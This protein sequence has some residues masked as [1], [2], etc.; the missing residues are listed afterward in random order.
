MTS[1]YQNTLSVEH[2]KEV[3][4]RPSSTLRLVDPQAIPTT[5]QTYNNNNNPIHFGTYQDCGTN[6][7]EGASAGGV[8]V[9][10]EAMISQM[11]D[12]EGSRPSERTSREDALGAEPSSNKEDHFHSSPISSTSPGYLNAS[13][14][15][16]QITSTQPH[17]VTDDV[18]GS[19]G[20]GPEYFGQ[21]NGGNEPVSGSYRYQR[22]SSSSSSPATNSLKERKRVM[23]ASSIN[24][25]FEELRLHVPTFPYEKR[26]SKIDTLRLAIAYIALLREILDHSDIMEPLVY[27]ERC[28][29][30]EIRNEGTVG[31]NTSDLTAR[32]AWINWDNLGVGPSR[33]GILSNLQLSSSSDSLMMG[34]S[35][36]VHLPPAH[37][38]DLHDPNGVGHVY[39]SHNPSAILHAPHSHHHH[40]HHHHHEQPQPVPPQQHHSQHH[41]QPLQQQHHH[42]HLHH[43]SHPQMM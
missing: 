5:S 31:W 37:H 32:L 4:S 14:N 15:T 18:E 35:P 2:S 6:I 10:L 30:G 33:R 36:H 20:T 17:F 26:L 21:N 24:A 16:P 11:Y 43:N 28:L 19:A 40:Q 39:P 9:F 34:H 42:H 27:V 38:H 8:G 7:E 41:S 13:N 22:A 3:T 29:R 23:S 25:A 12:M 1:V